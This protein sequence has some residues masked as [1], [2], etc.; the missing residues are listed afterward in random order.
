VGGA[1]LPPPLR[2]FAGDRDHFSTGPFLRPAVRIAFPPDRAELEVDA[3]A[4]GAPVVLRA[5]GGVL[6]LTWLVDG[7]RIDGNSRRRTVNWQPASKGFARVSVI[8]A[9]GRTD[10]VT[11]RLR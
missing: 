5:Q 11:I 6:P 9:L 7:R 4:D 10:R 2:R 3:E 8:D 1:L